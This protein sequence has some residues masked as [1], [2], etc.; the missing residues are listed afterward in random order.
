MD[1]FFDCSHYFGGLAE[2]G[3][4]MTSGKTRLLAILKEPDMLA[5]LNNARNGRTFEK[6]LANRDSENLFLALSRL[7]GW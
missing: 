7:G 1:I 3:R 6:I 5:R 4:G 2:Q